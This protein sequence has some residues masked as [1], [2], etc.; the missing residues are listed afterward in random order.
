LD[1]CLVVQV[2]GSGK[3]LDHR[4][5]GRIVRSCKDTIWDMMIDA[6]KK[7]RQ[8]LVKS[9]K[10]GNCV[11]IRQTFSKIIDTSVDKLFAY[12]SDF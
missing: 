4:T 12:K 11:G 2:F 7:L 6:G 10:S 5:L 3:M 9:E 8:M 1:V